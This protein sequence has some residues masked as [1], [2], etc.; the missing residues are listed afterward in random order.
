MNIS[1]KIP[2]P[3]LNNIDIPL[4][5]RNLIITGKNGSGKTSFLNA[6][7]SK[8]KLH[9]SKEI[10]DVNQLKSNIEYFSN[11]V[12]SNPKGSRE[13][14]SAQETLD[15]QYKRLN[16]IFDGLILTFENQFEYLSSYDEFKAIY[17]F[18]DAM[19]KAE[20]KEATTTSS[21]MDEKNI[22]QKTI[23][24]NTTFNLDNKF[25]QHLV[26]IKVNQ[27]LAIT[28]DNDKEQADRFQKW[29]DDFD[30]QLKFLFEDN[31]AHLVFYRQN[32]KFKI[33]LNNREFDF[34]KLSSGYLAIF[35]I[36]ADL[37]VRSEFFETAPNELKGIV[38]IDEIDAHLHISLQKK[39]L[40]FFTNLFPHLQFIVSTH[41]PFVITSTDD[42]TVVYDISSGEFIEEDLSRYSY[43]SV[44]KGLFHVEIQSEQLKSEI[45]AIAN[46]LN[47]EP[48]S[49]EKLRN[50]LKNI[51]P[52]MKQ[53]DVESKS[54]YFKALNH[55]LDNQELGDLDV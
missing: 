3:N 36:L 10:Q 17:V 2:H 55:L 40:P 23:K 14:T 21:L 41:S 18:F 31:S 1:G 43:E 35:K 51:I 13:N 6:F 9:L 38:L 44:I 30:H 33:S 8:I 54:F 46:I 25:E 15:Q 48:N 37:L 22:A 19:R 42:D 4:N 27:S 49:Y 53:L 47:D 16:Q 45:K 39:I 24:D 50:V 7:N 5:G 12:E 28:A 20:I 34:Q 52:S 11:I 29:F 32:Y 26:N